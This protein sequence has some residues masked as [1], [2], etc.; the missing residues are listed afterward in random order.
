MF[1]GLV[2]EMGEIANISRKDT[3]L[4]ITIKGNSVIKNVKIGDSIAVNGICLTVTEFNFFLF[5]STLT[6]L[7]VELLCK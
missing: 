3:S 2:E 7:L 4:R 1:T 5:N 6:L